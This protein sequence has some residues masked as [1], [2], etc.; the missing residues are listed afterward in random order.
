VSGHRCNWRCYGAYQHADPAP[1][2]LNCGITECL[3]PEGHDGLHSDGD[4]EWANPNCVDCGC[5]RAQEV[6]P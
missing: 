5:V 3:L 6:Q 4:L 1:R 2:F